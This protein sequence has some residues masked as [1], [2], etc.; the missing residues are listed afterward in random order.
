MNAYLIIGLVQERGVTLGH[1][2]GYAIRF[3]ECCSAALTRIQYMTE[4]V[5]DWSNLIRY[6]MMIPYS[7]MMR[8]DV[9]RYD[10]RRLLSSSQV[11]LCEK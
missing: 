9:M 4:G 6:T 1:E 8:C 5:F 3:E 10:M 2:V 7:I 11:C